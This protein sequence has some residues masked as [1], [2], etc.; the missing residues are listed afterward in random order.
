MTILTK[1]ELKSLFL[2]TKYGLNAMIRKK[3]LQTFAM[4][5]KNYDRF[6]GVTE[7]I[8]VD[9]NELFLFIEKSPYFYADIT[10]NRM[11]NMRFS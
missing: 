8:I 4:T 1:K 2:L 5:S 11:I 3:E 6:F 7:V 9:L 10:K